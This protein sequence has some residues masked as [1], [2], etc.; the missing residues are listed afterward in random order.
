MYWVMVG[1]IFLLLVLVLQIEL[2]KEAIYQLE[3]L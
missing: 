1:R 2:K 3:T